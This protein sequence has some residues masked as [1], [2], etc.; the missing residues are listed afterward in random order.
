MEGFLFNRGVIVVVC[1]YL[2]DDGDW[3][4]V[5]VLD[6]YYLDYEFCGDEFLFEVYCVFF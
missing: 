5:L 4:G 3:G 1:C 2:D 6:V